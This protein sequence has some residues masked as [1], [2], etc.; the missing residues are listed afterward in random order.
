MPPTLR[1]SRSDPDALARTCELLRGGGLAAIGTET[2][3]GL[4]ADAAN[5]EA[6]AAIFEAKG[7]PRF[8]PLIVHVRDVAHSERFGLADETARRLAQRFWPGPLTMVLPLRP[9]A[10]VHPIALGGLDTVALRAP[11]GAMAAVLE[12]F[13]GALV[14]P[15]ANRSGRVSPTRADHVLRTLD[16]RIDLVLD[17]GSAPE[18]LESTIVRPEAGGIL[19]LRPG[20]VTAEDLSAATGLPVW[21]RRE[22]DAISA[23]GQLLSHYAPHGRVRLDAEHPEP[24]E[25]WIGFGGVPAGTGRAFDLSPRRDLREA[26][27]NL[28]TALSLF[29]APHIER[30]AV[31]P[32]PREGL[33]EAINDRL[34][35]A[36]AER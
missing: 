5:G 29:D 21:R 4:A 26:A 17:G 34:R 15:S 25:Y 33:G 30:I 9:G 8:N 19:L 18:G 36:A 10:P 31:A 27:A 6:V 22:G 2:V 12:V 16:G 11:R 3:Y 35:R 24:G 7:R 13:D 14:A 28:F 32:I 1:L 23:P 20:T